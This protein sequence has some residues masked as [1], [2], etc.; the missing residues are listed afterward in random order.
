MSSTATSTA[1]HVGVPTVLSDLACR[2]PVLARTVTVAHR[3]LYLWSSGRL[4]SGW[5]G[6]SV[7]VLETI[8]RRS[9]RRHASALVYMDHD[10]GYAVIPAN[11]G[12]PRPPD[13][14]LNLQANPAGDGRR[15]TVHPRLADGTDRDRLWQ[16]FRQIAPIDHYQRR[17]GRRLPIV[18]LTPVPTP[19][20]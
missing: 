5:F 1:P 9:G 7:L 3:A 14:W 6:A 12:A 16:R 20:H 13:W 17:A 19:H 4:L 18:I 10:D 2:C 11:A 15:Q 8:G